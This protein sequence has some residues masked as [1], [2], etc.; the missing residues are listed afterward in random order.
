VRDCYTRAMTWITQHYE[1]LGLVAVVAV[2]LL[3]WLC[4]RLFFPD[5]K[6]APTSNTAIAS[7]VQTVNVNVAPHLI[8]PATTEPSKIT[9]S[10]IKAEKQPPNIVCARHRVCSVVL[11]PDEGTWW[12]GSTHYSVMGF[13]V[14][15]ENALPA[16]GEQVSGALNLRGRMKFFELNGTIPLDE[17]SFVSRSNTPTA[18]LWAEDRKDFLIAVRLTGNGIGLL[19]VSPAN[20]QSLEFRKELQGNA[21]EVD[22]RLI[23]EA[24]DNKTIA[25]NWLFEIRLNPDSIRLKNPYSP[26]RE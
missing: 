20:L 9:K 6:S 15:F 7:P 11:D 3:G 19:E 1:L 14:T 4:K 25:H 26:R 18:D 17:I 21:F 16:S 2:P 13:V 12:E 24:E 10:K 8:P 23:Y 5:A 22:F